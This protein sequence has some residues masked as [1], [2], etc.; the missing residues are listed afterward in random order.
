M[1]LSINGNSEKEKRKVWCWLTRAGLAPKKRSLSNKNYETTHNNAKFSLKCMCQTSNPWVRVKKG[2]VQEYIFGGWCLVGS[3]TYIQ[4]I[5][6]QKR[7][8]YHGKDLIP[9]Y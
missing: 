7:F 5:I 9:A 4:E 3:I 8:V 6:K 2:N 1:R